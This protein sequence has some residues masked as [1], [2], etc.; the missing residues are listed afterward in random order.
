MPEYHR[1][2]DNIDPELASLGRVRLTTWKVV[3]P[4]L[5]WIFGVSGTTAANS[6]ALGKKADTETVRIERQ[7]DRDLLA[8]RLETIDQ[9]LKAIEDYQRRQ[10]TAQEQAAAITAAIAAQQAKK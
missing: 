8:A 4:A 9:R 3:F 10:T 5:A 7:A 1:K 6:V 2:D